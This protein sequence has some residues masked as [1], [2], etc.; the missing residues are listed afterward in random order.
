MAA[1]RSARLALRLAPE[2]LAAWRAEAEIAGCTL[3]GY[4]EDAVDGAIAVARIV[5]RDEAREAARG[6]HYHSLDPT[7]ARRLDWGRSGDP[8]ERGQR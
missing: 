8:G 1:E 4:I 7:Q 6:R 2:K 5:R 3:T